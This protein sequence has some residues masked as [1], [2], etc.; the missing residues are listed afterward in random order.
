[1]LL[2]QVYE[3]EGRKTGEDA[4]SSG[5]QQQIQGQQQQQQSSDNNKA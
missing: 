5:P 2:L 4:D 1:L 3:A